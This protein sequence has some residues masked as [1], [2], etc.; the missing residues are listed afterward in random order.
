MGQQQA[1]TIFADIFTGQS[2]GGFDQLNIAFAFSNFSK[3]IF[4]KVKTQITNGI[5]RYALFYC[6]MQQSRLG[7]RDENIACPGEFKFARFTLESSKS[8]FCSSFLYM[9]RMLFGWIVE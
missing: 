4:T 7:W 1:F 5:G 9:V 6:C 3:G 2:R 8:C